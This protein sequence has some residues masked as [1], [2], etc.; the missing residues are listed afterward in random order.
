[1]RHSIFI[2]NEELTAAFL[3][4]TDH[5]ARDFVLLKNGL[6]HFCSIFVVGDHWAMA[7]TLL[8]VTVVA[9]FV[10]RIKELHFSMGQSLIVE[11]DS[12]HLAC[13]KKRDAHAMRYNCRFPLLISL[14]I[15]WN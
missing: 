4:V 12:F 13:R 7:Q 11:S 10:I 15:F 1:M 8:E 5:F 14:R 9:H 6:F 2:G 3:K